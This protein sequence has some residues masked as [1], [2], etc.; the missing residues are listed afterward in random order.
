M[1]RSITA[2]QQML[3]RRL[4][5]VIIF[6]ILLSLVLLIQLASFQLLSPDVAREFQLRSQANYGSVRRLPA[7]RG[8]IYDRDGQV[9]AVNT[10]QYGIGIS[11]NLV[12]DER[13]LA[14]ELALILN[15]DELA[16]YQRVTSNEPWVLLARP[17]SA[18]FGQRVAAL[19]NIATTIDPIS[20][21]FYPQGALAAQII[22]F[23]IESND[24]TSRGAMGVESTYNSQLAG[25]AQE[26]E[27]SLIPFTLPEANTPT[28]R[29]KDIVL[30]IDRDIQFLVESELLLAINESGATR[31]TI[32]V[33]NP[34]NGDILAMASYPSFDPNNFTQIEDPR[35]LSNPAISEVYEPGSVMKVLTVAGALEKGIIKPDWTYNDQG[36][37]TVGGQTIYNWDRR[38][39]GVTD[40]TQVLVQSLNVGA[41][42][43]AVEM[44]TDNFYSMMRAFGFG[45]PTRIDLPGEEAGIVKVPG[46]PNWS[47]SDL[48]TNSYGQG[49]STTPIQM[50]AAF[51]AIAN[52]GLLYQPRVVKQ[53]VDGDQIINAQPSARR[54]ISAETANIVTEMMVRTVNDGLDK[55]GIPGYNIAGKTGT[56]EIPS[57]IGYEPN[58]SIVTFIGFLPADDPQIVVLVKLD[59]PRDYWGS[60]VAAPVFRRLAE[61]LVI[62]LEIPTDDI[63]LALKSQGGS[64]NGA[65]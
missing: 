61:R 26:S 51:A 36:A 62:L 43:I 60:V 15:V 47:E 29:G 7:E 8:I 2:Q 18:E 50:I 35:L 40:A 41:A 59:R 21:R 32:I 39:H 10:L 46:D 30:T 34:R 63:R 4:P 52:D 1:Q 31:G 5:V 37:L 57:P 55:A 20:K 58:A 23:V 27:V 17:V 24:N 14:A 28:A 12:T 3:N 42:T 49:I 13:R 6:L 16:V 56:A 33:M 54:V 64:T 11:P 9:L 44:G 53:I 45:Q 22:G 65:P 25:K 19:D 38:S 48:A